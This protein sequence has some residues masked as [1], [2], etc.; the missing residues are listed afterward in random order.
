MECRPWGVSM[1]RWFMTVASN[2]QKARMMCLRFD[3]VGVLALQFSS[4]RDFRS[5]ALCK[6]SATRMSK[7]SAMGLSALSDDEQCSFWV[8]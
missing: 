3:S 5:S 6:L 8:T 1:R 2:K 4:H 7:P